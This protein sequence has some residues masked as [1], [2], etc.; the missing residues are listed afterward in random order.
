[1]A[2]FVDWDISKERIRNP[3]VC[4]QVHGYLTKPVKILHLW[5]RDNAY[6]RVRLVCSV[7]YARYI[8]WLRSRQPYIIS[9]LVFMEYY[10]YSLGLMFL[11]LWSYW[12]RSISDTKRWWPFAKWTNSLVRTEILIILEH[13]LVQ[14]C[15]MSSNHHKP[16]RWG[17]IGNKQS[18]AS[19]RLRFFQF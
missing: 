12:R 8:T 4:D 5:A 10:V 11:Y 17:L 3:Q 15:T 6:S 9:T 13:F 19:L 2:D 18:V 1:M 7:F 16:S 14:H